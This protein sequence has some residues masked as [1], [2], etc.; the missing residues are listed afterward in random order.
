[1]MFVCIS[2]FVVGFV[3]GV[4]FYHAWVELQFIT[5]IE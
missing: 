4:V 3:V 5:S 1:M 2:D